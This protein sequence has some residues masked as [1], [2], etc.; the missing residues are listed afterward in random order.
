MASDNN[1][2]LYSLASEQA[3]CSELPMA[4]SAV[5]AGCASYPA[6]G[7][8]NGHVTAASAATHVGQGSGA[9]SKASPAA[10]QGS[11]T[12]WSVTKESVLRRTSEEEAHS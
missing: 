9:P 5:P 10:E 6:A 8:G 3:N 1:P 7:E 12:F 11:S 4:I 2:N